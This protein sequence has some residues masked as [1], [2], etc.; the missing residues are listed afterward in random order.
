MRWSETSIKTLR[1]PARPLGE[2]A[3]FLP[4][5][6]A[7]LGQR[8][9]ERIAAVGDPRRWLAAAGLEWR[10]QDTPD[11]LLI[12]EG[13]AAANDD[14]AM[15]PEAFETPGVHTIAQLAAF[16]SMP[17]EALVKSVVVMIDARPVLCLVR[18]DHQLDDGKLGAPALRDASPDEIRTAF[19]ADPGSLG[20][21][22]IPHIRIVADYALAGLS[23]LVTGANRTGWHLRHVKP[24]RDFACEFADIRKGGSTRCLAAGGELRAE[25]FWEAAIARNQDAEGVALPPALAPFAVV[26][27]PV[28]FAEPVQRDLAVRLHDEL[29]AAGVDVL[30]DDRD[31]RPGAKFKDAELIGI[32]WRITVGKKAAE[33]VVELVTRSP[34]TVA[35]MAAVDAVRTVRLSTIENGCQ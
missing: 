17:K 1:D 9:M 34:R 25:A 15:L 32:P 3:G 23:G 33:G 22:G 6:A 26:V 24:G 20:P 18:G 29:A 2:R 14:A 4:L 28:Q 30:L 7:W 11:G 10:E 12:V 21:V 16:A 27:T 19:G 8:C 31:E 13:Q 5:S 35:E